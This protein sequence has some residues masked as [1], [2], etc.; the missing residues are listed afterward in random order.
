MTLLLRITAQYT[1]YAAVASFSQRALE[2]HHY[3]L[4]TQNIRTL[5]LWMDPQVPGLNMSLVHAHKSRPSVK[6]FSA[7]EYFKGLTL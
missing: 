3:T 5:V 2:A 6:D 1:R 7:F 4:G